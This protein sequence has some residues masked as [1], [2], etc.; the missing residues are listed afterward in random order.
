MAGP[1][2]IAR[3][4]ASLRG[5]VAAWRREGLRVGFVPTMGALHEGHL[6]LVRRA[7]ALAD[8]AVVSIFVNPTQFAP[9]EDLDRYPRDEA[10][11]LALLAGAGAHLAWLPAVGAMYPPGGRTWVTVEGPAGG[12]EDAS[13]PDFFRG[14]ATVVTKLLNAAGADL[15]VFGEKDYQQLLVV[16]RLVLDLAIPC[17]IV[18]YPTVREPDGLAM[19]SRNRYLAPDERRVA[20]ALH[21][22]LL[23]ATG[24]LGDGRD[25]GPVLDAAARSLGGAG[26]AAV[27]YLALRDAETLAPLD[28]AGDRPARLLA[29]AR[30]GATRL[31][32]NV[33]VPGP[34]QPTG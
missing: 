28:R 32:D 20:P 10:G 16:R 2:E 7:L 15:A 11:D 13:R 9:G 21:R 6:A 26:F 18:A 14:V 5:R 33:A 23:E 34:A 22:T 17:E 19:S 8:R 25:A 31:I 12:L 3:D 24:R 30:L 29:A 27:D 1:V 4:H